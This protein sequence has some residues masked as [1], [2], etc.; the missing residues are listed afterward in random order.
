MQPTFNKFVTYDLTPEESRVGASLNILQ[1][2][3]IQNRRAQ[4]A[5]DI[6]A[7]QVNLRNPQKFLTDKIFL[8]GQ[9]SFADWQLEVAS[10]LAEEDNQ[11]SQAQTSSEG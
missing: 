9:L 4:I 7:L 8:E 6:I 2:A 10:N 5:L 3:V 1:R 11:V